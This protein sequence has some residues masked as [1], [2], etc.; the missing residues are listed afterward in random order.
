M[1]EDTE[2]QFEF[3]NFTTPVSG[4][5]REVFDNGTTTRDKISLNGLGTT[6]GEYGGVSMMLKTGM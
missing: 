3:P 2:K 4:M 5:L 6:Q 1:P